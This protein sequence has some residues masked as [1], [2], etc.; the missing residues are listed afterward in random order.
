MFSWQRCTRSNA[1]FDTQGTRHFLTSCLKTPLHPI[2]SPLLARHA[3]SSVPSILHLPRPSQSLDQSP[4][5]LSD[6]RPLHGSVLIL[7]VLVLHPKDLPDL[8]RASGTTYR[9][10]ADRAFYLTR[11]EKALAH[12]FRSRS[13]LFEAL[14]NLACHG[15]WFP[16]SLALPLPKQPPVSSL[17]HYLDNV[18]KSV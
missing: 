10:F 6:G 14:E 15:L 3:R 7:A 4:G 18:T 16:S 2:P 1:Q 12:W 9:T 17:K 11:C 8:D 13:P 5:G